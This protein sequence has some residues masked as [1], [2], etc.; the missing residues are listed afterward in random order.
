LRR[1]LTPTPCSGPGVGAK[2]ADDIEHRNRRID[3]YLARQPRALRGARGR[4]PHAS[5]PPSARELTESEAFCQHDCCIP[6]TGGASASVSAAHRDRS[7]RAQGQSSAPRSQSLSGQC[8]GPRAL[9]INSALQ[10]GVDAARRSRRRP[11][12][13]RRPGRVGHAPVRPSPSQPPE[14]LRPAPAPGR[15]ARRRRP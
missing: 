15:D 9:A 8:W 10:R 12:A 13:A 11:R 14:A 2:S 4:R 7:R 1:L 3:A 6:C 5:A